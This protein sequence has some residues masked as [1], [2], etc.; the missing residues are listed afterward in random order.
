MSIHSIPNTDIHVHFILILSSFIIH[1]STYSYLKYL[2]CLI[3]T[4]HILLYIFWLLYLFFEK[5]T[6]PP[7]SELKIQNQWRANTIRILVLVQIQQF[8]PIRIQNHKKGKKR[9]TNNIRTNIQST[10]TTY[11]HRHPHQHKRVKPPLPLLITTNKTNRLLSLSIHTQ[12]HTY[13][14]CRF[15]FFSSLNP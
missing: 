14:L 8:N 1:Y 2:I 3:N 6:F 12:I 7:C 11:T 9:G 10:Y 5:N 13:H 15:G 4:F